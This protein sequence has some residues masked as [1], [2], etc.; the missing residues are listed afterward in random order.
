MGRLGL[1]CVA[2]VVGSAGWVVG[3]SGPTPPGPYDAGIASLDTVSTDDGLADTA[4]LDAG[5]PDA[6]AV[7]GDIALADGGQADAPDTALADTALADTAPLDTA[8]PDTA[9]PDTMGFDTAGADTNVADTTPLDTNA[10][11]TGALDTTSP[12]TAQPDTAQPDTAQPD[13]STPDAGPALPGGL[14]A[15]PCVLPG[16]LAV[17]G[18]IELV[19]AFPKL[20]KTFGALSFLTHPHDGSDRIVVVERQGVVW[21]FANDPNASQKTKV[22]DISP[23]VSTVGEGGLLSVAFHPNFG[24]NGRLFLSYTAYLSGQ[25]SSVFSEI[26]VDPKT[27]IAKAPSEKV[28]LTIAQPYT[29]HDGGQILFD[30]A[31]MLVIGMGDGGSAGDPKNA[32]QSPNTLLGAVLRIDVDTIPAGKKYGIPADNPKIA[33]W[34]PELWA[35]GLRNP[36]RMSVD[37]QTGVLWAGDVGQNK[38]EEVTHVPKGGNLGWRVLE[39]TH[40]Y[41]PAQCNK[42]GFVMP[43][44]E[45]SHSLGF[46]ITG[47]YV[48]RGTQHPSL[49]GL[50]I[51]GDYVTRR[52]WGV[53]QEGTAWKSKVLIDK[54]WMSPASFGEDE[55]GEIYVVSL[56]G[57]QKIARVQP[58]KTTITGPQP[59]AK[60]SQTGCFTNLKTLTPAKGVVPYGVNA[61]LWSDGAAKARFVVPPKATVGTGPGKATLPADDYAQWIFP[62][63]T[64]LIKHFG[65]GAGVPGT[66]SNTPVETRFM[67]LGKNG[68]VFWTYTW[69]AQGTD[70]D[71]KLDG[72]E[73]SYTVAG[74]GKKQVWPQPATTACL[75]CHTNNGAVAPLGL[76]TAQLNG[77]FN[78][79]PGNTLNQLSVWEAGGLLTNKANAPAAMP[80]Q[81]WPPL[82]GLTAQQRTA[83]ARAWLDVNCASCHKPG[84]SQTDIDLRMNTALSATKTCNVTPGF[85][86]NGVASAKIVAP[87]NPSLSVLFTRINAAP[88]SDWFMPHL[89]VSVPHTD[90]IALIKAWILGLSGC[91]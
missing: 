28:L 25:F 88:S 87:G 17:A 37:R 45:Y 61:P 70:A 80:T 63:D 64:I 6:D 78:Y 65:L 41:N 11:D 48:Y 22:L 62:Q 90:A 21:A 72:S 89:G 26:S 16:E 49:Q 75:A 31:G 29:N 30:K 36:W 33:G 82:G 9:Q 14:G 2:F 91:N 39:G 15:S 85:G 4:S 84:G 34:A 44:F 24:V 59:P 32:G 20:S 54:S 38:W 18:E 27:L 19:D 10:P 53:W 57:S 55:A 35:M 86:T 68:W 74:T 56:T 52:F 60:L 8:Q 83:H 23:I 1:W 42:A 81:P 69:N 79:G 7:A 73:T 13:T 5:A 67:V 51:F 3:C 76:T 50:Y 40:C 66:T 77:A 71:L 43:V 47:G 58:K 12:D 46:S